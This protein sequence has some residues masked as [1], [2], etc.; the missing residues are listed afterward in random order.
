MIKNVCFNICQHIDSRKCQKEKIMFK[1][2][3]QKAFETNSSSTHSVS[4]SYA[5]AL[6]ETF[7]L[8]ED[9]NLELSFG[10]FGWEE[11]IFY[12][13]YD[14][15]AYAATFAYNY[16][17]SEKLTLFLKVLKEQTGANDILPANTEKKDFGYIDHQSVGEAATIFEDEQSLRMFLFNP[18][19]YFE[20]DNDNH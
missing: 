10:D 9:N 13:K 7:D 6:L 17:N 16:A 1:Q 19:S 12:N 15:L 14:R 2:I 18:N 20:T 11:M 8:N 5:D 3:R 4:I